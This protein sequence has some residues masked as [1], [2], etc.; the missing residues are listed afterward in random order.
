MSPETLSLHLLD[1]D[2][3]IIVP[4]FAGLDRPA[5]GAHI[6]QAC[7]R[8]RGLNVRIL[9]ANMLL[10]QVIGELEYEAICFASTSNL[11]GE[12]F[13][14]PAAY[15]LSAEVYGVGV[16]EMAQEGRNKKHVP[17]AGWKKFAEQAEDAESWSNTLAAQI[18]AQSYGVIGCTTTFE[19]TAASFALLR[20]IKRIRPET[21]VI[22]GGANCESPMADGI[23]SLGPEIDFLFSGESED[24]FP[25]FLTSL[26]KGVLPD[27]P[28]IYGSPCRVMDEV[29]TPDYTE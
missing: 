4:P 18:A 13:F 12:R 28:V 8:A 3:L 23:L 1:A 29:P 24:T 27:T 21:I 22:I 5:L 15:G 17:P 11:L 25:A 26:K 20:R 6:H 2:A 14:A 10:A 16:G 9:Y 7:A 19:Q